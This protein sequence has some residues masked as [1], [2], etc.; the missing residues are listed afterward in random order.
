MS[1]R[2]SALSMLAPFLLAATLYGYDKEVIDGPQYRDATLQSIDI[3][4]SHLTLLQAQAQHD[5]ILNNI[6]YTI[7]FAPANLR[8]NSDSVHRGSFVR[9]LLPFSVGWGTVNGFGLFAGMQGDYVKVFDLTDKDELTEE[10]NGEEQAVGTEVSQAI[11]YAG[12]SVLGFQ[13]DAG[14]LG[15]VGFKLDKDGEFAE[16]RS[17]IVKDTSY[18]SKKPRYVYTIHHKSGVYLSTIFNI[19]SATGGQTLADFKVNI[20]PLENYLPEFYGLPFLDIVSYTP[21]S[22]YYNEYTVEDTT[23]GNAQAPKS[24]RNYDFSYG[25]DNL[26]IQGFRP[27]MTLKVRPHVAF[28]KFDVSYVRGLFGNAAVFGART[29]YYVRGGESNF[30]LDTFGVISF[31]P[32]HTLGLSYSYNSPD[33]IT[34]LPLPGLHVWGVQLIWGARETAKKLFPYA[35]TLITDD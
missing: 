10:V 11:F 8:L 29:A 35:F 4:S 13:L 1:F 28:R 26:F 20:Q 23:D 32:S 18:L 24:G 30:S 12:I 31:S 27:S 14:L 25:S 15:S 19:D 17:Q 2:K 22:D 16:N 5:R 6:S 34:F 9:S 33:N 7:R 21:L 3:M